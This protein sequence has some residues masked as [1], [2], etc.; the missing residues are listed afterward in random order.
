MSSI[1]QSIYKKKNIPKAVREQVWLASYG[2]TFENKCKIKWCANVINVFD[3]QCGHNIPESK[4]GQTVV[5][6]LIPLCSRCNQSMNNIYSIDEWNKFGK[7][8][9]ENKCNFC[10]I[11]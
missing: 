9:K 11:M 3:F 4:G 6:N 1:S 5:E 7:E 2:K 10:C 8:K